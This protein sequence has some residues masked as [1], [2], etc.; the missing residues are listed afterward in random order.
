MEATWGTLTEEDAPHL[1]DLLTAIEAADDLG[2]NHTEADVRERL[3][4]PLLDLTDGTLAARVG[5]RIVAY[6]YLPVKQNA[7][8][9]HLMAVAG[10][11]HPEFRRQGYG[12]RILEWAV[13]Q[14]P[15]LHER[16]FPGVGLEL[17]VGADDRAHDRAALALSLGF[18]K[19]RSFL[20]MEADLSGSLPR[21]NPPEGLEIVPWSPELDAGARAVRNES[22][23]DHWGSVPHTEESWRHYVTGRHFLPQ[24]SFLACEGG[25]GGPVREGEDA[26]RD[27][28]DT[29]VEGQGAARAEQDGRRVVGIVMAQEHT[30]PG[31]S[32]YVWIAIVG[33]LAEWRGRG[34]AG[35]LLG[36]ALHFYRQQ[37]YA[38]VE[39]G[40]DA[41]NGTGAVRVYE[42]AGFHVTNRGSVYVRKII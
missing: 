5:D 16:R 23:S 32:P 38:T 17:H 2:E 42:K 22:F 41:D 1:A 24:G 7:T 11:V 35:A 39:L 37:G 34:V 18:V 12:T 19:S 40:V 10:G 15:K 33:T 29:A 27:G 4:N 14:A 31:G 8:G 21:T 26:A 36:H 25:G 20:D 3:R 30:T 28:R 9:T 13:E 6:G